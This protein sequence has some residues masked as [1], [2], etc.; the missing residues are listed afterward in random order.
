MLALIVIIMRFFKYVVYGFT[1]GIVVGAIISFLYWGSM[2]CADFINTDGTRTS[3]VCKSEY[4]TTTA[5]FL[6]IPAVIFALLGWI[7]AIIKNR[8]NPN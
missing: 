1:I 3:S 8:N 7:S 2:S 5:M 4:F 6:I